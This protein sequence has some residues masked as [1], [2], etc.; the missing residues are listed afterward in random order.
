[1]PCAV[2]GCAEGPELK[3]DPCSVCGKPTHHMCAIG[4]FE[5]DN[6]ALNERS[7][8]ASRDKCSDATRGFFFDLIDQHLGWF[9]LRLCTVRGSRPR[10]EHLYCKKSSQA[11]ENSGAGKSF[12]VCNR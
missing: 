11:P 5:G 9:R 7:P 4:V 6:S 3:T 10:V 1:M 12:Q 2:D 8:Y